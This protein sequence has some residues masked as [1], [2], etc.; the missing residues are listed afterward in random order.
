MC[1]RMKQAGAVTRVTI[2]WHGHTGKAP[3]G[4]WV[5]RSVPAK[6]SP[7]DI[8]GADDPQK[9]VTTCWKQ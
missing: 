8:H 3:A 9:K 2:I 5:L 7:L 4:R 6:T 1:P